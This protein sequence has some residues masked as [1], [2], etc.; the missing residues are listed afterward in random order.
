VGTG[1]VQVGDELVEGVGD[2]GDR[3]GIRLAPGGLELPRTAAR[4]GHRRLARLD[5]IADVEDLPE[6]G[7]DRGLVDLGD[8][9]DRVPAAVDD[10]HRCRRACGKTWSSVAHSPDDPSEIVSTGEPS[11]RATMSSR[12][13]T[14]AS[15]DSALTP[16]RC[17][18]TGLPSVVIP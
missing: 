9:G 1:V 10:P 6:V 18:N 12:N 7:P 14:H 4:L 15:V 11:P 5:V 8:L 13:P 17:K 3:A 2:A 16:S